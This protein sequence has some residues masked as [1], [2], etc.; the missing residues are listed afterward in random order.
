MTSSGPRADWPYARIV[1]LLGGARA[2]VEYGP[3]VLIFPPNVQRRVTSLSSPTFGS[4]FTTLRRHGLLPIAVAAKHPG[5]RGSGLIPSDQ[6]VFLLQ[7]RSWSWACRGQSDNW[8]GIAHAAMDAGDLM[9]WDLAKRLGYQM[10][11]CEWRLLQISNAYHEQLEAVH[12]SSR[13]IQAGTRFEDGYT[14]HVYLA[15]QSFFVDCCIFRD[16]LAEFV[17]RFVL[18]EPMKTDQIDSMVGLIKKVLNRETLT[19]KLLFDLKSFSS[20]GGWLNTLGAYRDLVVHC[21]PLARSESMLMAQL[22]EVPVVGHPPILAVE[23][24]LPADPVATQASRKGPDRLKYLEGEIKRL[25]SVSSGHAPSRDALLYC[26]E[27]LC[28]LTLLSQRMMARSPQEPTIPSI[29]FSDIQA[30][31]IEKD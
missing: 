29:D 28:S 25:Q 21:A 6:R 13:P 4:L 24:P 3:E 7:G 9:L 15:L 14:W 19:D 20:S 5:R 30:F 2:T 27:V 10:E 11:V 18:P 31:E 12:A 8:R 26:Y 22:V 1:H 17:A 23:L 16:Y